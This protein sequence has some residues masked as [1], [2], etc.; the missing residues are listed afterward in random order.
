V[1][2]IT[3]YSERGVIN[4]FFYELKY[5]N[6]D[7]KTRLNLL[8][9]FI[10]M[11]RFPF[12]E[13]QNIRLNNISKAE[14]LIEQSFSD[15]GDADV[16]LLIDSEIWN[17]CVFIEAKVKTSTKTAWKLDKQYNEFINHLYPEP[18]TYPPNSPFQSRKKIYK[19]KQKY[20]SSNLFA[21]LYFKQR[22]CYELSQGRLKE[23]LDPYFEGINFGPLN[24]SPNHYR[25]IGTNEIVQNA[26]IKLNNYSQNAHFVCLIPGNDSLS[27][28]ADINNLSY[29]TGYETLIG[30]DLSRW[31]QLT[32]KQIRDF[33][34]ESG[35]KFDETEKVFSWNE[36]QIY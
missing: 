29:I 36:N 10:S 31:G 8:G 9:E 18:Y 22:L 4:S 15:F 14:I 35:H 28:I 5:F 32:W 1:I 16:L 23:M 30:W 20:I 24:K 11:I 33:C 26:I 27:S 17:F 12:S 3:G 6:T 25:K 21:Q 2:R 13:P 19:N 7:E 34:S